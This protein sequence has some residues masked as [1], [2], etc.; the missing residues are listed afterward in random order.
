MSDNAVFILD[1]SNTA[2]P[3]K[4]NP[5]VLIEINRSGGIGYCR[6]WVDGLLIANASHT[7]SD[8]YYAGSD[9][10]GFG[11]TIGGV[12]G[13]YSPTTWPF[14]TDMTNSTCTIIQRT[15]SQFMASN[16][17]IISGYNNTYSKNISVN[18]LG[19]SISQFINYIKVQSG[20][21]VQTNTPLTYG[22]TASIGTLLSHSCYLF[23]FTLVDFADDS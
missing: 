7:F 1:I 12:A 20:V 17:S 18:D 19:S 10:A 6:M 5:E 4:S 16:A 13:Y 21:S 14:G 15:S 2:I 9:P 23:Y 3:G 22:N 11:T 8:S